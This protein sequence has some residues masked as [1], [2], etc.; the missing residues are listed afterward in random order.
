ML[1]RIATWLDDRA[2][3]RHAGT[4]AGQAIPAFLDSIE[5]PRLDR[6]PGYLKRGPDKSQ[7]KWL[8]PN[9][10]PGAGAKG[11]RVFDAFGTRS[12]RL[13]RPS[14]SRLIDL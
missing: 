5:R 1:K 3:A 4:I 8:K 2:L 10:T 7:A 9:G 12:L 11:E 14:P 13:F 6:A